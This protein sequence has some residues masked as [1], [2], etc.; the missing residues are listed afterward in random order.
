ME[1]I[2]ILRILPESTVYSGTP[3]DMDTKGTCQT[4]HSIGMSVI[5]GL[6]NIESRTNV[7]SIKRLRQIF[8]RQQNV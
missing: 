8:L 3:L 1:I 4:V 5:S 2:T 7:L 6:S